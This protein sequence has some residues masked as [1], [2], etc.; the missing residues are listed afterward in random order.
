MM[1]CY[2]SVDY[3]EKFSHLS[4]VFCRNR[5]NGQNRQNDR[6]FLSLTFP[7][8]VRVTSLKRVKSKTTLPYIELFI[9][10][11]AKPT[12]DV[13]MS[14]LL[15]VRV[16]PSASLSPPCRCSNHFATSL[17]TKD[18]LWHH[19][20]YCTTVRTILSHTHV[21]FVP[22]SLFCSSPQTTRLYSESA[23]LSPY[24]F[25]LS[26]IG[27]TI[28]NTLSRVHPFHL[29]WATTRSKTRKIDC[30]NLRLGPGKVSLMVMTLRLKPSGA[31]IAR[32]WI[33]VT[34]WHYSLLHQNTTKGKKRR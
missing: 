15:E 26:V 19:S 17:L 4:V 10:V 27:L 33:K 32:R 24:T 25:T 12:T 22:C 29:C 5:R 30:L 6:L 11:P 7:V 21:L 31:I 28:L 23:H 1:S 20:T 18:V 3:D 2:S 8:S 16:L 34:F 13:G 14:C 9:V